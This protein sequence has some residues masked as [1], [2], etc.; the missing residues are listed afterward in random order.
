M[1]SISAPVQRLDAIPKAEG[2]AA[3]LAD[4]RFDG[5]LHARIVASTCARG[6]ARSIR[7]PDLPPGYAAV[8]ARDI[9]AGGAN[10]I[11]IIKDDSPVFADSEIRFRGQTVALLVGPDRAA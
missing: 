7:Y 2:R 11:L 8:D 9:P 4:L 10:R 3:Y 6:R 1:A 5:M